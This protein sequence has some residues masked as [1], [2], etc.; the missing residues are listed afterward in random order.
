ML[1]QIFPTFFFYLINCILISVP[2]PLYPVMKILECGKHKKMKSTEGR[3]RS[4]ALIIHQLTIYP[5]YQVEVGVPRRQDW[6]KIGKNL[7]V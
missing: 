1:I 2:I 5:L 3:G 6:E 4:R 7:R